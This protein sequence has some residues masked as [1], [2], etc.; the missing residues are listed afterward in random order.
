MFFIRAIVSDTSK[1]YLEEINK[2]YSFNETTNDIDI[3]YNCGNFYERLLNDLSYKKFKNIELKKKCTGLWQ[4]ESKDCDIINWYSS[5][6]IPCINSKISMYL[7]DIDDDYYKLDNIEWGS[8]DFKKYIKDNFVGVGDFVKNGTIYTLLNCEQIS[9][10]LYIITH[11]HLLSL[12]K[13]YIVN[14][15][16]DIISYVYPD[17]WFP[18][19]T[20]NSLVISDNIRGI[21]IN[22]N[23]LV[24]SDIATIFKRLNITIG[25]LVVIA[26][27]TK[28]MKLF[29]DERKFYNNSYEFNVFNSRY[30]Y[31]EKENIPY[32]NGDIECAYKCSEFWEIEREKAKKEVDTVC[33]K[34]GLLPNDVETSKTDK[35]DKTDKTNKTNIYKNIITNTFVSYDEILTSLV[36]LQLLS[37]FSYKSEYM[38]NMLSNIHIMPQSTLI[39][40]KKL[41]NIIDNVIEDDSKETIITQKTLTENYVNK[42]KNDNSETL[43]SKVIDNILNYLL[44]EKLDSIN[45]ND[46][47]KD[48]V[49]LG[50]KKIRKSKGYVYGLEDS[51]HSDKSASETEMQYTIDKNK[52]EKYSNQIRSEP[53]VLINTDVLKFSIPSKFVI[54][55]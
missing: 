40:L 18:D 21:C 23:E 25:D 45:K 9:D 17:K 26:R 3:F 48:L 54:P 46:I 35:T 27:D 1:K 12:I 11:N 51:K 31:L 55:K 42:Y 39:E 32:S 20:D 19:V 15:Y 36:E 49:D 52:V 29:D 5:V 47:G 50:V 43:A 24:D 22:K 37:E 41:L 2:V 34:V 7:D 30:M 53:S 10:K 44:E 16:I 33:K 38:K 8:Y 28:F 6:Y 13:Q 14:K 4:I